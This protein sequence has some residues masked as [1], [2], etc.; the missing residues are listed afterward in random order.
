MPKT[1]NPKLS[2]FRKKTESPNFFLLCYEATDI[3]KICLCRRK[4][5]GPADFGITGF[6]C[7]NYDK[8]TNDLESKV[9]TDYAEICGTAR[10]SSANA[11]FRNSGC[12]MTKKK[13]NRGF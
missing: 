4:S 9:E 12:F 3:P 5:G 8:Y 13:K 1:S 6:Y 7:I 10:F 11:Y 2:L